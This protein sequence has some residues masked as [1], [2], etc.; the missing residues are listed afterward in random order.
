MASDSPENPIPPT[1]S[2]CGYSMLGLEGDICP[3]CGQDPR[4]ST[5]V[6]PEW[7][8][9]WLS[10]S[11]MLFLVFYGGILSMVLLHV[12][13][14]LGAL[15]HGGI[16]VIVILA[17]VGVLSASCAL[18][19]KGSVRYA[20]KRTSVFLLLLGGWMLI[21]LAGSLAIGWYIGT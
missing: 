9:G 17:A 19:R 13:F 6:P 21:I 7:R 2:H 18:V 14:V 3:E 10:R 16:R 5:S 8:D 15:L 20:G 11:G 12:A 4:P 1:C